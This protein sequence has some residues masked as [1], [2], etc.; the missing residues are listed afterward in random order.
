MIELAASKQPDD[1]LR[2]RQELYATILT[3][4]ERSGEEHAEYAIP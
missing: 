2:L 3:M 1:A 4:L